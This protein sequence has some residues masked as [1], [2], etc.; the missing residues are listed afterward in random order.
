VLQ[1]R[2]SWFDVLHGNNMETS[3]TDTGNPE[4]EGIQVGEGLMNNQN[5]LLMRNKS[6]KDKYMA[7]NS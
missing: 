1:E 3:V 7:K 2:E 5:A 4:M 6:L